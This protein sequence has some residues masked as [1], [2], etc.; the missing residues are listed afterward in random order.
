MD[1]RWKAIG[2]TRS[3][4]R[5]ATALTVLAVVAAAIFVPGARTDL[6]IAAISSA[7]I[8]RAAVLRLAGQTLATERDFT[9]A[10]LDHADAPVMVLDRHGIVLRFNRA[11]ERTSGLDAAQ[12]VGRP[13]WEQP[14]ICEGDRATVRHRFGMVGTKDA[15]GRREVDWRHTSGALRRITWSIRHFADA[16]GQPVFVVFAGVDVTAQR[17]AEAALQESERRHRRVIEAAHDVVVE[18]D[19]QG[20]ITFLSPQWTILS[21]FT[22]AETLGKP[23][24]DLAQPDDG[25]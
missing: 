1:P 8:V 15:T 10:V 22:V 23:F 21:G 19:L 18:T 2:A 16:S 5:I 12:G 17:T 20:R 14:F 9:S 13:L 24:T 6:V 11:C 3:V 7:V 25:A 4:R